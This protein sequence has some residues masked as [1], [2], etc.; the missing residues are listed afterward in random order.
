M[1][2]IGFDDAGG[3]ADA[4]DGGIGNFGFMDDGTGI[5]D[6]GAK[7]CGVGAFGAGATVFNVSGVISIMVRIGSGFGT[8]A[9]LFSLP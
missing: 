7:G 9:A 1:S 5:C 6:N 2:G 4:G 3:I 8:G